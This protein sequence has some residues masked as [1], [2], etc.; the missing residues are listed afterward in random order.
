VYPWDLQ[1]HCQRLTAWAPAWVPGW[2]A[3]LAAN[4]LP[5]PGATPTACLP[6]APCRAALAQGL[7]KQGPTGVAT[8]AAWGVRR[9]GTGVVGAPPADAVL[10]SEPGEL[11]ARS[12]WLLSGRVGRSWRG[13]R[14][15]FWNSLCNRSSSSSSSSSR[16]RGGKAWCAAPSLSHPA[17]PFQHHLQQPLAHPSPPAPASP[18]PQQQLPPR[19][20]L[21]LARR[22][23]EPCPPP[24]DTAGL[25]GSTAVPGSSGCAWEQGLCLGALRGADAVPAPGAPGVTGGPG[26]RAAGAVAKRQEADG[27]RGG[28]HWRRGGRWRSRGS[29]GSAPHTPQAAGTGA[30]AWP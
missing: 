26:S 17:C 1:R 7:R 23:R 10:G 15:C 16:A 30:G 29:Q 12:C 8:G 2:R 11:G 27:A 22:Q 5:P 20:R 25:P 19:M 24:G 18:S 4:S 21:W 14:G 9:G 13:G 6:E 3:C 28:K